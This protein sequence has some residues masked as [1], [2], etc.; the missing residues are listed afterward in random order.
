MASE[1][2]YTGK[3]CCETIISG[4]SIYSSKETQQ[5]VLLARICIVGMIA[6]SF[7]IVE[8]ARSMLFDSKIEGLFK[9]LF[10]VLVYDGIIMIGNCAKQIDNNGFFSKVRSLF[11]TNVNLDTVIEHT[12][13]NKVYR[14]FFINVG[15]F[16]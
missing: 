12:I 15:N 13:L 1:I 2:F 6:L 10:G 5:K 11:K 4:V 9:G 16:K 14:W 8:T 3:W 7:L